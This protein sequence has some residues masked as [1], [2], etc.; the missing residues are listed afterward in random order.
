MELDFRLVK[1]F[2]EGEGDKVFLKDVI[3]LLYRKTFTKSQ[4]N[5]LF[6]ICNG[7]EKINLQIDEFMETTIGQKREGGIN[8]VSQRI[9]AHFNERP[10]ACQ[11]SK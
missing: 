6:I 11:Y 3:E 4:I 8:L 2:V 9:G 10:V 5:D 7:Y 1:F